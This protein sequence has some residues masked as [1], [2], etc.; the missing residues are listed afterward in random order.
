MESPLPES[1][2]VAGAPA[3]TG[4]ILLVDDSRE[5]RELL[6]ELLGALGYSISTADGGA[7]ALNLVTRQPFD[8]I[9]LDIMMPEMD[10]YEVLS[11]LK[12]DPETRHMPVLV[13]SGYTEM[14]SVV[15]CVQMGAEDYLTKPFN[16]V[17]LQARI[18]ACLEKKRLRD[19]EMEM[20]RQLRQ[21]KENS[22]RLLLNILPRAIADRLQDGEQVI[23]DSFASVTVLF[24]D[25]VGFSQ[26]AARLSANELVRTLNEIFS[27]FD[28]LAA[29]YGLEKIKTIGDAYMAVGGLPERCEDHAQRAADMALAMQEEMIQFSRQTGFELSIRI[30]LHSGPVVAGVIGKHKF[31]YDL[32]GDTVNIASRMESHGHPSAIQISNETE[33]RLRDRY[34]MV[35]RGRITIKGQGEL[36][37][38]LLMGRLD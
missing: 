8:L 33:S 2:P 6:G 20:F 21:A 24:A 37:T 5:S 7:A 31:T 17:L 11:R 34:L 1:I 26:L 28:S 36:M 16:A 9:I 4:R 25:I 10:G 38:Y 13:V 29:R 14:D 3:P 23:V 32:W 27:R 22:D 35:T 19:H 18:S 30:G 12:Q 15:R